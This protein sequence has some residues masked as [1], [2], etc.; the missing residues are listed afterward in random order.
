MDHRE[1]S[2][3]WGLKIRQGSIRTHPHRM[4]LGKKPLLKQGD[5]QEAGVD[6]PHYLDRMD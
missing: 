6:S 3:L 4:L 5:N 2:K 1:D